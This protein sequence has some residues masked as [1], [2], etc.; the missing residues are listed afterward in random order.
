[1]KA[2]EEGVDIKPANLW[3]KILAQVLGSNPY[4]GTNDDNQTI[5]KCP[6]CEVWDLDMNYITLSIS[7]AAIQWSGAVR[8]CSRCSHIFCLIQ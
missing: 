2:K 4:V 7:P 3:S 8:K 1:M 6:R 5:I